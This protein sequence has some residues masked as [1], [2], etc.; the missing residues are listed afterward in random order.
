[1]CR[2]IIGIK[3]IITFELALVI[4][5]AGNANGQWE[6]AL[7]DTVTNTQIQKNTYLQSLDLDTDGFSHLVWGQAMS[8]N[9]YRLYYSSNSPSGQWLP[10]TL[11]ADSTL[12]CYSPALA[13]SPEDGLPYIAFDH[14]S[15]IALAFPAGNAWQIEPITSNTQLDM[16]PTIAIDAAGIIHLAWITEH[17][18]DG[19]Y[20]IA[21]TRGFPGNWSSQILLDS[22]LGDYGTGAL[23][24]I[25]VT[26]EGVSHIVYRG[27]DYGSYHIHHAWNDSAGG[28]DWGYEILFSANI[29]D[30]VAC[31]AI[32]DNGDLHL[33]V[34]GN[35][36]WGFPSRVHYNYQPSG[37]QWQ[38]FEPAAAPYSASDP[39]IDIDDLGGPHL[40]WM[41]TDGNFYAGNI[42]YSYMDD[43]VWQTQ[44]LVGGDHFNPSFKIGPAGRGYVAFY[45]GGNLGLYDI[46][47]LSGDIATSIGDLGEALPVRSSLGQN[48]PNPFNN[49]TSFHY[50][51]QRA[52]WVTIAVYDLLG[53][54]VT[55]LINEF[56]QPG[57]YVAKWQSADAPSG[58]YFYQLKTDLYTETKRCLVLK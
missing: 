40:I 19:A 28:M 58:I 35:D 13:V 4:T 6:N 25:A 48:Y 7:L 12:R 39:S 16:V 2:R 34:S 18:D 51:I 33:G 29:N 9:G 57:I 37:L 46:Y 49:G 3:G 1:M 21:Y 5:I 32:A 11:I 53:S 27:G 30:F 8:G 31:L 26:R 22:Y 52:G 42:Y 41:E 15:E 10:P 45:T 50:D 36:G 44:L 43:S 23:P 24:N 54:A 55:I 14:D 38:G 56:K 47:H 20:H 17:P